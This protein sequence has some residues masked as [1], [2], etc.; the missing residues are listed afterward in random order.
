MIA[1][2]REVRG[3][4]DEDAG[5]D[6]AADHGFQAQLADDLGRAEIEQRGIV[7]EDRSDESASCRLADLTFSRD[8]QTGLMG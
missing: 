6:H 3:G 2:L 5:F 7:I 8:P 1:Q 4:A